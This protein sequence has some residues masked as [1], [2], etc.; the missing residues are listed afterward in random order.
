MISGSSIARSVARAWNWTLNGGPTGS[1]QLT[2]AIGA[3]L[4]M[5]KMMGIFY[6]S[7]ELTEPWGRELPPMDD[8]LWFHV[9]ISGSCTIAVDQG[10]SMTVR[11]GDLV[12]VPQ[13]SGHRA[14]GAER[15]PTQSVLDLPHEYLSDDY[16]VLRH[17]G[18]GDRTDIVCGG[19]RFDHPT[20]RHLVGELPGLIHIDSARTP[21]FVG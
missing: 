10:P 5:I 11:A 18:G 7:S 1:Q 19:V 12:L 17:G 16:A 20:A 8:C 15:A 4:R 21:R 2:P 3:V 6:F 14:W 13:G 9:V